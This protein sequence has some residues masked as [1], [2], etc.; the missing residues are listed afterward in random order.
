MGSEWVEG[1]GG[2][3][4]G[5]KVGGCVAGWLGLLWA[6]RELVCGFMGIGCRRVT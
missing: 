1:R 4:G 5:L 2:W 6:E 3:V